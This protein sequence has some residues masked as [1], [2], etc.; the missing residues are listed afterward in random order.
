M[1]IHWLVTG[2]LLADLYKKYCDDQVNEKCDEIDR[3]FIALYVMSFI[4]AGGW[5]SA[6]YIYHNSIVTIYGYP[7]IAT[8]IAYSKTIYTTLCS[9]V[10]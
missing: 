9:S 1:G 5:V 7:Y 8:Y 4:C 3:K 2:S 6:V 10:H